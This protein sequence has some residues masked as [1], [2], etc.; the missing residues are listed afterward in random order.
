MKERCPV[1]S[2]LDV[3]TLH[4]HKM[5]RLLFLFLSFKLY[6]EPW[7]WVILRVRL[8]L[9]LTHIW[10]LHWTNMPEKN[11]IFVWMYDSFVKTMY[12]SCRLQ[13]SSLFLHQTKVLNLL[14]KRLDSCKPDEPTMNKIY[15]S[16]L[17]VMYFLK[18]KCR[19]DLVCKEP[20]G[21]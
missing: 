4:R 11:I 13:L 15:F 9:S 19:K 18:H 17:Q 7:N 8:C 6:C 10:N 16:R 1:V 14:Y 3:H 5:H 12:V 21:L 20:V 2:C